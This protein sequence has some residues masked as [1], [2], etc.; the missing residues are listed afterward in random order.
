[1][2]GFIPLFNML[3]K[4]RYYATAT[5]FFLISHRTWILAC[6]L[7]KEKIA[8]DLECALSPERLVYSN[9]S[10][11]TEFLRLRHCVIFMSVNWL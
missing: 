6:A 3:T 9:F 4:T 10:G 7:R 2:N 1:M 8:R 11:A 5:I